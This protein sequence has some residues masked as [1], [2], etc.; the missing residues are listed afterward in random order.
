[1]NTL[2]KFIE[3]KLQSGIPTVLATVVGTS[4]SVPSEPGKKLAVAADGETIGTVGGGVLE[5]EVIEAARHLLKGGESR[6]LTF[7][8]DQEKAGG[9]G[10]ICGGTQEVFLD[11][12][13]TPPTILIC[14][15]GHV[16]LS[17]SRLSAAAGFAYV[18][19]D[20]RPEFVT[21]ERFPEAAGR[22]VIDFEKEWTEFPVDKDTFIVIITRG[23]SYD[24]ECL[25]AS[26]ATP[27]RYIG[28][29]GSRNKSRTIIETLEEEGI[30]AGSDPR[31]YTPIGLELGNDSPEE[32]AVSILA[33]IVAVKSGGSG[34]HLADK[35]KE[36]GT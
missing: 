30:P 34:R 13:M 5:A 12:L 25:R 36:T 1:M 4:G 9:L 29:I 2:L 26:L 17:L 19:I 7:E 11:L 27:A 24:L 23:H 21:P 22:H 8:L 33:E 3:G 10:M 31:L 18:V 20:D 28:M 35:Y 14:G 15:G 6:L 16:G 32:I